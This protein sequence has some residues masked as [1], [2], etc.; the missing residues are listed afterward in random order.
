M[1][2]G[3]LEFGE[4]F[5]NCATREVLEETGLTVQNVRFLTATNDVMEDEGKHYVTIFMGA[6]VDGDVQ[7]KVGFPLY[8][9]PW[10]V[11]YGNRS[12]N[13]KSALDGTGLHGRISRAIAR[14]KTMGHVCLVRCLIC[15]TSGHH[16][17]PVIVSPPTLVGRK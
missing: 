13:R 7:P 16:L 15:C 3:H 4:S 11:A 6:V 14:R 9:K 2:G 17:N 10:D 5:E 1:P 8:M 12:L